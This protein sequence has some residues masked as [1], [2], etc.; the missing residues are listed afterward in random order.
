MDQT[1]SIVSEN[2]SPDIPF[3]YSVNPYRGCAHGCA[4]CYARPTHEYFGLSAGLDFETKIFVKLRA[5]ELLEQWLAEP[6]RSGEPIMFS[7]VTDCYQPIER[8]LQLTR[9]CLEVV[10]RCR[11]AVGIVTKNALVTR[12]LDLLV[13]MAQENL[14]NVS[15]SIT[16]LDQ[17]LTRDLEPRTSSPQARLRAIEQLSSAG[18]PVSVMVAPVIPGLNDTEIPAILRAAAEA[19]ARGAGYVLLRLPLAVASVFLEWLDRFR[20]ELRQRVENRVRET[21]GG[22][23]NSAT[24]GE[25]MRGTGH[26]AEQIH[27]RCFHCSL[28][29]TAC[30]ADCRNWTPPSF[31]LRSATPA[32]SGFSEPL[33]RFV[34]CD[35]P[36]HG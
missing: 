21:R 33:H 26:L 5:P 27:G 25:R 20:P 31:G 30:T 32:S 14:V 7:G 13:P 4:Y 10:W 29:S 18:V 2:D 23:L 1:K 11:Q 16:S 3:R 12:D 19:G 34:P 15:I 28:V 9:R 35:V 24:F 22:K 17:S 8:E 36:P 6:A